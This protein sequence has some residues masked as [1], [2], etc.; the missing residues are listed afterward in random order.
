MGEAT[1]S[2]SLAIFR[3]FSR[4]CRKLSSNELFFPLEVSTGQS[5]LIKYS[6]EFLVGYIATTDDHCKPLFG[7]VFLV[8]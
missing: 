2:V 5:G 3:W 8:S 7:Q 1:I 4:C 6:L